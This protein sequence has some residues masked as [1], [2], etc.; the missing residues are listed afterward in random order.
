MLSYVQ[1]IKV[2]EL[3]KTCIHD[4]LTI[5]TSNVS[6]LDGHFDVENEDCV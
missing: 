3:H 2:I 6:D 4:C 1:H 5:I